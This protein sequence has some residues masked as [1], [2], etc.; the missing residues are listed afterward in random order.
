MKAPCAALAASLLLLTRLVT[1]EEL[2]SSN[3][4]T[5]T[6]TVSIDAQRL[7]RALGQLTRQTGLQFVIRTEDIAPQLRSPAVTGQFVLEDVLKRLLA[8]SGLTYDP[9]ND[10]TVMILPEV[11][12]ASRKTSQAGGETTGS[13][14]ALAGASGTDST[15]LPEAGLND[16]GASTGKPQLDG[17][18]VTGTHIRG[19]APVGADL[20]VL[21]HDYISNSG[22]GTI[23][24]VLQT[25]PQG[26]PAPSEIFPEGTPSGGVTAGNVGRSTGINLRGLGTGTTLVLVDGARQATTGF[27]GTFVDV[28]SIPMAAVERIEILP[29]GGS[30]QYGSDAIGG[31]VNIILRKDFRGFETRV[32]LATYDGDASETTVSQIYGTTW[33]TGRLLLGYEYNR[34]QSLDAATR[35]YSSNG[36]QRRNGGDN[37]NNTFANPGNIIFGVREVAGPANLARQFG[38]P[39]GQDGAALTPAELLPQ[40]NE[41]NINEGLLLLGEHRLDS[42]FVNAAQKIND[43]ME[44]TASARFSTQPLSAATQSQGF[45]LLVPSSNPFFVDPYGNASGIVMNYG[46][47]ALPFSGKTDTASCMLGVNLELGSG[48][49]GRIAASYAHNRMSYDYT[50]VD[51][52]AVSAALADSN[53]STALNIFGDSLD[54][55]ALAKITQTVNSTIDASTKTG[56]VSADGP[57][58]IAKAGEARLAFGAEYSRDELST[59]AGLTDSNVDLDRSNSSL[60]TE[61]MIP[62]VGAGNARPGLRELRISLAARHETYNTWGSSPLL[63]RFGMD[64]RPVAAL[65]FRTTWGRSFKAPPLPDTDSREF[66]PESLFVEPVADPKSATGTANA[67]VLKGANPGLREERGR[68]WTVGLE[69][70]PGFAPGS[71]VSLSYFSDTYQ[72]RVG[73][74]GIQGPESVLLQENLWPGL[75]T[76]DPAPAAV[77]TLCK[78][79]YPDLAADCIGFNPTVIIDGRLQNIALTRVN[80]LDLRAT[81]SLDTHAGLVELSINSSL[82]FKNSFSF[83]E[84]SPQVE[85]L[86]TL[87]NAVSLR[88]RSTAAWSYR[89][90]TTNFALNY[91]PSYRDPIGGLSGV[92]RSISSWMTLDAALRYQ[93]EY[94]DG[95]PSNLTVSA[96]IINLFNK[97]PPFVDQA[98]GYDPANADPRGRILGIEIAKAW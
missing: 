73:S 98:I 67:L 26:G 65:T 13:P 90:M 91:T 22:H 29:D 20:I 71:S 86:N 42:G 34:H 96:N 23:A 17:V 3:L 84:T 47:P 68:Q 11:A 49:Q 56:S 38:I 83:S 72:D 8:H 88:L 43:R 24:D 51:F 4:L 70:D 25:L 61:L 53:P 35:N 87:G 94:S 30:A 48:W 36:D 39:S 28:S 27:G 92:P 21:D 79:F 14:V 82:L 19:A 62:L 81:H 58:F 31:V 55:A 60:Y 1:A 12:G 44:L 50:L 75:M 64:W 77:A 9:L 32:R 10:R 18:V 63:P 66:F 52:P 78:T 2:P 46:F 76:R 7:D 6:V 59:L 33:T 54:P 80:G 95:W 45:T 41:H 40:L 16:R 5:S 97:Q 37:F 89:R 85:A 74:P 93:A 57:I 15:V 69:F